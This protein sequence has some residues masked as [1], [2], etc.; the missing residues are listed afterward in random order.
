MTILEFIESRAEKKAS[1]LLSKRNIVGEKA[2]MV[3]PN[4]FVTL[5]KPSENR[6]SG[7]RWAKNATA[8]SRGI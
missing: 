4:P 6:A 8:E 3:L 1:E 5:T 7:T 2:S